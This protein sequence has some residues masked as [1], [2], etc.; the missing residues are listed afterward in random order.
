MLTLLL[1]IIGIFTK[2]D[3]Q[4]SPGSVETLFRYGGKRLHYSVYANSFK[5]LCNKIVS[6]SAWVCR[7]CNKNILA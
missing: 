4:V 7:R 1:F 3:F 5:T 2:Y 6:E